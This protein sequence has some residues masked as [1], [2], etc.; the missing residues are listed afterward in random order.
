MI[1]NCFHCNNALVLSKNKVGLPEEQT[2]ECKECI[3]PDH[4]SSFWYVVNGSKDI[5]FI[6]IYFKEIYLAISL[7]HID[8]ITDLYIMDDCFQHCVHK[9]SL[10]YLLPLNINDRAD[11]LSLLKM[12]ITFQ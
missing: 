6:A 8:N 3:A 10:N 7:N 2:F 12:W 5:V 1:K 11:T 4:L 9:D